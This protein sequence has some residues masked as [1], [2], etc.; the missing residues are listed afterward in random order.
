MLREIAFITLPLTLPL[1]LLACGDDAGTITSTVYGEEFIEEGI[2]ASE[3]VD[4]WAVAFDKFLVSIGDTKAKAGE[5][6][7]EVGLDG[8]F[9]VDLAAASGGAGHELA[10]FA[11]PGGTYDHYAYRL[12]PAADAAAVNVSTADADAMR[13][14]GYSIRVVG[15]A[16]KAGV[17]KTFD[18]GFTLKVTHA[19]CEVR[20]A[21]DGNAASIEATIHADH[22]FYDD[23]VSAEPDVAFQLIADADADADGAITLAELAAKDIRAEARYQVGSLEDPAGAAI[24]NLRQYIEYQATTLGHINGEGHCADTIVAP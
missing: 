24:V 5:G 3:L 23:A 22:L 20:E 14:A 12:A 13:A 2:P 21:I 1:A 6:G 17:T 9:L 7:V 16:T 18:W 10:S 15:S 19:H 4:G 8:F 11:A